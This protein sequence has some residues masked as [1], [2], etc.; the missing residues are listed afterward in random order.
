MYLQ[1]IMYL[2]TVQ[3]GGVYDYIKLYVCFW[4]THATTPLKILACSFFVVVSDK[5]NYS[6][7]IPTEGIKFQYI[8]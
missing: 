8:I 2:K 3:P 7:L 6:V 5:L 1:S 4:N